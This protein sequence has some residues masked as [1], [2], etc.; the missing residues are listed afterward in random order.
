MGNAALELDQS[1]EL[2][3]IDW[4][5]ARLRAWAEWCEAGG[6]VVGMGYGRNPIAGAIENGGQIIR[7]TGPASQAGGYD[8]D[9][10]TDRAVSKLPDDLRQVVVEHYRHADAAEWKR[11]RR[12]GCSRRTYY[13]RLARAHQSVMMLIRVPAQPRTGSSVRDRMLAGKKSAA[14]A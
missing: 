1:T 9:Y 12:C 8:P 4:V 7:G 10:E 14:R 5:D 13:R 11:V 2:K 6:A 3:T